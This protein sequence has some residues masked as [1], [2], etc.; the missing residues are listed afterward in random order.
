MLVTSY[1]EREHDCDWLGSGTTFGEACPY[2]MRLRMCV[3]G[4]SAVLSWTCGMALPVRRFDPWW[5]GLLSDV[6]H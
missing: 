3:L 5:S 6:L 4:T 1:Q 2:G